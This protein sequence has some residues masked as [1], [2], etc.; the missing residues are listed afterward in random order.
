M[1]VEEA[2]EILPGPHEV[3]SQLHCETLQSK[4]NR[5]SERVRE[6]HDLS[7]YLNPPSM[8]GES[9]MEANWNAH[10]KEF[11]SNDLQLAIKDGL[12]K[13]MRDK[14]DGHPEDYCSLTY[15]YWCDILSTIEV[16]YEI[17]RAAVKIKKISYA[18]AAS[19]S[20]NDK[21]VSIPRKNKAK[22]GVLR[23]NKSPKRAH[24]RHHS[25]HRYCVICKKGGMPE[26]KYTSHS[27]EDCT[28]VRTNWSIKD[29]T[30]GPMRSRTDTVKQYQKSKNKWKKDLKYLNKQNK[31]LYRISKKYGSRQ[32]INK[33][34]NIREKASKKT[35]DSSSDDTDS[36]SFLASDIS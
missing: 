7:K 11:T 33:S 16:K 30:G 3:C 28:G 36:D 23:S 26:R 31:M 20:D 5:C 10:N 21:Y 19:L 1:H 24:I 27:A 35:S 14:L 2:L 32:E 9:E 15:E 4:K 25:I 29:G 8:K 34:K 6:M 12:P 18:R 13:S 17:K 22:N